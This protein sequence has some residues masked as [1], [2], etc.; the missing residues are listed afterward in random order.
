MCLSFPRTKIF[1]KSK[2]MQMEEWLVREF[3]YFEISQTQLDA[4]AY[5]YG[6][7]GGLGFHY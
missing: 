4:D 2:N 6:Q 1:E 5:Y 7:M 3:I